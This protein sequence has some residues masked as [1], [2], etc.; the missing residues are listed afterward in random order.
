MR[1]QAA[2][3]SENDQAILKSIALFENNN[4]ETATRDKIP[5]VYAIAEQYANGG[6]GELKRFVFEQTGSF[7]KKFA[8]LLSEKKNEQLR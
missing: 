4:I 6:F 5:E 3:Y 8:A 7:T 2:L 1:Y